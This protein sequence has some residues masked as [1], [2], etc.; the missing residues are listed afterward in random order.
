[1]GQKKKYLDKPYFNH[2]E[3]VVDTL[4]RAGIDD[5]ITLAAAYLHDVVEKSDTK[6]HDIARQFG[7]DVAELVFWMTDPEDDDETVLLPVWRL[8][9]ARPSSSSSRTSSTTLRGN[10]RMH[11]LRRSKSGQMR[12]R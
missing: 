2:V 12:R 11:H 9:R 7:A 3:A 6:L 4:R 5:A 8:S 10:A 1:M